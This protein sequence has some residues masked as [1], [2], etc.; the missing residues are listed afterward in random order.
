M[1]LVGVA[2]SYDLALYFIFDPFGDHEREIP[3]RFFLLFRTLIGAVEY[4]LESSEQT[5]PQ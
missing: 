1:T 5:E 2:N 3:R 4:L